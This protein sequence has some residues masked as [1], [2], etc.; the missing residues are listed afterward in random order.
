MGHCWPGKRR[1]MNFWVN[2]PDDLPKSPGSSKTPGFGCLKSVF[3]FFSVKILVFPWFLM[4]RGCFPDGKTGK[5][6]QERYRAITRA[7]YRRAA[8][9]ACSAGFLAA[10]NQL[11]FP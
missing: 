4:G 2:R 3:F 1:L 8:G 5:P 11:F 9:V 7:H 6:L 10:R